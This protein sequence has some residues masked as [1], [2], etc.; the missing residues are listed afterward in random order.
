MYITGIEQHKY[1]FFIIFHVVLYV[2]KE[3]TSNLTL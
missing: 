1:I 2:T 3:G